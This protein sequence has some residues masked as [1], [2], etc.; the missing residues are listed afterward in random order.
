MKRRNFFQ[1]VL[2]AAAILALAPQLAFRVRPNLQSL[3]PPE[4]KIL[5]FSN[6]ETW[7]KH[8]AHD[9]VIDCVSIGVL[10][11]ATTPF[12]DMVLAGALHGPYR[13]PTQ[14][15]WDAIRREWDKYDKFLLS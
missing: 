14:D 6:G 10:P 11:E 12:K 13:E 2:K 3:M 9:G 7:A 15:E 5:W 4:T 8:V 1:G